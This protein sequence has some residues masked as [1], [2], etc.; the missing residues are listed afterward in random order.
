MPFTYQG[1]QYLVPG[2]QVE[3]VWEIANASADVLAKAKSDVWA[4]VVQGTK[5][6]RWVHESAFEEE[7]TDPETK[8]PYRAY[9]AVVHI[10]DPSKRKPTPEAATM[11][12]ANL[13]VAFVSVAMSI[14][15]IVALILGW[16][17][18]NGVLKP[19]E[20][21]VAKQ[22]GAGWLTDALGQLK[23][24]LVAGAIVFVL[25]IASRRR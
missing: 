5:D 20:A 13:G 12:E 3:L 11:Y 25:W 15:S 2:D 16:Q 6:G 14:G 7:R 10:A 17:Y 1:K 22:P 21:R 18:I 24:P 4:K 9:V 23:W 8:I 19:R